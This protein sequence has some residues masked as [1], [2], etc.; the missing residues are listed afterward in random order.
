[1]HGRR[2]GREKIEAQRCGA[3][4]E[5]DIGNRDAFEIEMR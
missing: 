2:S 1:M 3:L 4:C 5:A